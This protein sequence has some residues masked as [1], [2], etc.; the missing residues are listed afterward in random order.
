M[1]GVP[2]QHPYN[3]TFALCNPS[4]PLFVPV[5]F[6][7]DAVRSQEVLGPSLDPHDISTSWLQVSSAPSSPDESSSGVP[8]LPTGPVHSAP[9]SDDQ[10]R[11][12]V[13]VATA[14]PDDV[15][16]I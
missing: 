1:D 8:I 3:T 2:A 6:S 9:T 7:L 12:L 14:A 10:L 11:L 16:E 15:T 5:G 13:K 4:C